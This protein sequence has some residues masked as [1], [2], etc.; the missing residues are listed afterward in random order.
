MSFDPATIE[1]VPNNWFATGG[2]YEGW[3]KAEFTDPPGMVEGPAQIVFDEFGTYE[4]TLDITPSSTETDMSVDRLLVRQGP[5]IE[6]YRIVVNPCANLTVSTP[7]GTLTAS[8]PTKHSRH[9]YQLTFRPANAHFDVPDAGEPVYWVLPL[10]NFVSAFTERHPALDQHPLRIYPTPS[11]PND[12]P[13]E[14]LFLAEYVVNQKNTLIVFSFNKQL[15]WI[16]PLADY[17]NRANKLLTE[18]QRR[19]ITSVMVGEVGDQPIDAARLETWF[20]FDVLRLLSFATGIEVSAPWLEFRDAHGGLVRR[21]HFTGSRPTFTRG[22]MTI[23]EAG[24]RR[25]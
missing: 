19:N 15:A 23:D 25:G 16:E 14:E 18:Q 11:L 9:Q 2:S 3:G 21:I 10:Q 8:G 24:Q 6:A 13:P 5:Y 22:H 12:V 4:V 17:Q 7:A 1:F 20:P